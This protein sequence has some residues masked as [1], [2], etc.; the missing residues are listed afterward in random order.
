MLFRNVAQLCLL[1]L[2]A[3]DAP[4]QTIGGCPA[5]PANNI[6]NA[7]VD[8]L[9]V[10]PRSAAWVN[11]IGSTATL[12][13][14]FG[15]ELYQGLEPGFTINLVTGS[16]PK[17]PI[18]I[19]EGI[20]ESE[21]GPYPIP[22]T[23]KVENGSDRHV[24]VLDTTNCLL[25]ETYD[26]IKNP[27]NS[28]TI[29]SGAIFDLRK[30]LLRPQFWTSADAAGLPITAGLARYEEILEGEIKHALR[31]TAP[32]TTREFL[33]PARHYASTVNDPSR[34]SMGARFRLRANFDISSFS[35]A[36]QIILTGLK[37]YGMMLAD[38]G[39]SWYVQGTF[40]PRWDNLADEWR[41]IPGSAFEAVDTS[42]LM[43]NVDSAAVRGSV[44]SAPTL[45]SLTLNPSA[46]TGG[47]GATLRI[48][49]SG[50]APT[51]GV[52]VALSSGNG[53]VAFS[54]PAVLI[55]EAS[56]SADV[57]VTTN[58]VGAQTIVA[59]TA[60]LAGLTRQAS[61][62]V[63]PPAPALLSAAFLGSSVTG[64]QPAT[65]RVTLSA[66]AGATGASIAL[67]SA[68]PAVASIQD[69]VQIPSGGSSADVPVATTAVQS[70]T[71]VQFTATM[72]TV[73]K[74][75]TLSVNPPASTAALSAVSLTNPS[76]LGGGGTM[77]QITL[78]QAAPAGG[79]TVALASADS[80]VAN[81]PPS[82][83][84]AAGSS[85]VQVP[86]TTLPVGAQV[87]IVLSA[88]AGGVSRQAVLTVQPPSV[89]GLQVNP[90]SVQGGTGA[91][92]TVTLNAKA[93]AAG[94]TVSLS[95]ANT[96]AATVP[97]T[98]QVAS[99]QT[100]A[101]FPVSTK[102]V[103]ANTSAQLTASALGV[104]ATVN[105]GI[106]SAPETAVTLTGV[107]AQL[108][109][110]NRTRLRVTVTLSGP[111]GAGG[112]LVTLDGNN[113]AV[114]NLSGQ[115]IRVGA[116]AAS[117]SADFEIAAPSTDV[118]LTIS[119]SLGSSTRTTSILIPKTRLSSR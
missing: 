63:N 45:Q 29:Y 61:L 100:S 55:P 23:A 39:G 86:V 62:T 15:G 108:V 14:D 11:S 51:G 114:V 70:Q 116:K 82:A 43:E 52:Q 119:A 1:S 18:V 74:P 118:T 99:G 113:G 72:G 50:S 103:S 76:V 69:S 90:N 66:P 68:T 89:S 49:L 24:L 36:T 5:F 33:W 105:L 87:Q 106:T 27:D 95:S 21:P 53:G 38:N 47:Q 2:F 10:H 112:A 57:P 32:L 26:S 42:G 84:V 37:R 97:S 102:T 12:H 117:A 28:W 64:G 101:T 98:V 4:A 71:Q 34:P 91:T 35:P 92:G 44:V 7:R 56:S 22:P 75:A 41:R 54:A 13:Q 16:Q 83:T 67:Q 46:V 111:A 65:L 40:D 96:A 73:S 31:F 19:N 20:D 8:T 85:S 81:L 110:A 109:R 79:F 104:S 60:T 78:T 93:P 80:S 59:F 17:V 94:F 77:L 107:S 25:Y 115:Q 58:A 9:P 48:T 88:S 3:V 30:N 6:W